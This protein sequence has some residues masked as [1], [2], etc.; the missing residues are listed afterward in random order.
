MIFS[1][2][3][4]GNFL[5][6]S[7]LVVFVAVASQ[8][9][10]AENDAEAAAEPSLEMP[11]LWFV[12]LQSA[13]VAEASANDEAKYRAKLQQEKQAFRAAAAAAGIQFKERYAYDVLWNGLSVEIAPRD[14]L[15]LS[16]VPGVATV[17]PVET[18]AIPDPPVAMDP[19]E[20]A[21]ELLT[22]I[23]MTGADDAHAAGITGTGVNV[24]V[25]D[26][27]IDY[28]HPD[29]GGGFGP[30]F[31]VAGGFDFVGDAFNSSGTTPGEL[32]PVPD[33]DPMDCNGHGTH[34]S[35]IVGA[36][37][38]VKGV[39]PNVIFRVY[40]V[41]GCTGTTT[42]DIMLAAMERAL[43]DG[44]Q[45]LNMS[46][47]AAFQWPQ[48]PT[49][50]GGD[51]LVNRGVVVVASAGNSGAN[52]LY[53]M[54]APGVGKKVIGVGSV[55]NTHLNAL[56]FRL[57]TGELVG[58][59]QM[60]NANPP[61]LSGTEAIVNAG[62]AC[63]VDLPLPP[64]V[65]GKVALI[66]RGLC[67][68][69][70]KALNARAAGATAALIYNNAP[71]IFQGTVGTPPLAFPVA[72]LSQADGL[73][74]LG[75]LPTT[76]T[77][78]NQ[79]VS[80]PN[81][82]GGLSSSFTSYGVSPDLVLKPDITA[83]GGL[84][85]STIPLAQG[86]Y[87]LNS[88]T[89]MSSPHVAGTVALLLE[90]HPNTP[91]QVVRD[92]LQNSGVPRLWWGNP[93]LGLF[94]NTHRQ[95]AGLVEID[96]AIN[97]TTKVTPGKHSLGET[98]GLPVTRTLHL[99]N[100]G[101]GGVTYDLSHQPAQATGPNTFSV[102]FFNAP[103]TVAFSSP[104]VFVSAGG[105]ANVNM[106]FTEPAGLANRGLFGGFIVLTPQGGGRALRVPYS[107]FKG[108]YQSILVLN[109]AA[110]SFGNPLLRP[111]PMFGASGPI[112]I[113]LTNASTAD[114]LAFILVHLDHQVRRVR[115]EIFDASTGRAFGRVGEF[116]YVGR[117][118][119]ATSFFLF[120][121]SATDRFGAP[122]PSGTYVIKLSVQKAL[123]DDG[124][125]AHWETWTSPVVTVI[126]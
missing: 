93:G 118:S 46:I 34:V 31:R 98:E 80:L 57:A 109:P 79:L 56:A 120:T 55:D 67:T 12:E 103:A 76:I 17:Y 40:K 27:G 10:A 16:R 20:S 2:K 43:A 18:V 6:F 41:F 116:N 73:L 60:S 77:W 8:A 38:T 104:S 53:S 122:V 23:K 81:A 30:G 88:G 97:A 48:Y 72:S 86:T 90:A 62:R 111:S 89:S 75:K 52:G 115:L 68:F 28:N 119:L 100:N 5:L 125:P 92:I 35:G 69:R 121:W 110:S 101:I 24:A 39:A 78:T 102:A 108:D 50:R 63:N 66:T 91:S 42:A 3:R 94:D 64:A 83:P 70:E 114:D 61:A 84:I 74:I 124:N 26:T 123:G 33:P 4:C 45:I 1:L 11:A 21:P 14:L 85:F 36:N 117:N 9:A 105:T 126:R 95:G 19:G 22:A 44:N 7:L 25:M 87:G 71:G 96:A 99:E 13:P 15:A 54:S 49:A 106:T 37:G 47:G 58:Y 107:G 82:S 32:T 113:N 51:N 65:A 112:T 29:L 59:I